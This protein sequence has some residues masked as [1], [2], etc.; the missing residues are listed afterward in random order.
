MIV[1][2]VVSVVKRGF[3]FPCYKNFKYQTQSMLPL[4]HGLNLRHGRDFVDAIKI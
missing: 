1:V 3:C 4:P 2:V